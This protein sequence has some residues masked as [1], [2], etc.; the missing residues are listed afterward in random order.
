MH[1]PIDCVPE[2]W[3]AIGDADVFYPA[4]LPHAWRL[5]YFANAFPAVLIP[6]AAWL[7]R[8][9]AEL[10]A[11]RSDVHAGFRFYLDCPAATDRRAT[12]RAIAAFGSAL[13]A[14]VRTPRRQGDARSAPAC[15][16]P[17]PDLPI[18][19]MLALRCP[20][21]LNADLRGARDWLQRLANQP[22]LVILDR[23]K[24]SELRAWNDLLALLGFG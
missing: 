19:R 13:A 20:R 6:A 22:C 11:W 14:L 1:H 18:P 16:A 3:W 17:E 21:P 2:G 8:S 10:S 4:D 7:D 23:P 9:Q 12:A 15:G 24:A 5:T